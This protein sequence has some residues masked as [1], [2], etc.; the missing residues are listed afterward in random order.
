MRNTALVRVLMLKATLESGRHWTLQQ[1]AE[2]F[3]VTTRTVR[4][5]LAALEEAGVPI[6]QARS[7]QGNHAEPGRWWVLS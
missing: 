7:E 4:R 3:N 5:D 1:L 2:R 6:C